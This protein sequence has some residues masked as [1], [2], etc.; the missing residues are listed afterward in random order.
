VK[1]SNDV[2]EVEPLSNSKRILIGE[3]KKGEYSFFLEERPVE[4]EQGTKT[5]TS[6]KFY[7]ASPFNDQL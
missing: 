4:S 1:K 2:Y 7:T 5:G 6:W 3:D